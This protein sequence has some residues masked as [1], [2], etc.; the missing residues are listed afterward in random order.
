MGTLFNHHSF[1]AVD[2]T[3]RFGEPADFLH[4][5]GRR[6]VGVLFHFERIVATSEKRSP[7]GELSLYN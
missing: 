3:S 5:L 6:E 1:M 7:L 4:L 2:E